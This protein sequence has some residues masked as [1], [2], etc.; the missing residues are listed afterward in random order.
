MPILALDIKRLLIVRWAKAVEHFQAVD[1]SPTGQQFLATIAQAIAATIKKVAFNLS[2]PCHDLDQAM[3][4]AGFPSGIEAPIA[5]IGKDAQEAID[6][7]EHTLHSMDRDAAKVLESAVIV[8]IGAVV[9]GMYEVDLLAFAGAIVECSQAVGEKSGTHQAIR[10][11]QT[12]QNVFL[13]D[14]LCL[15][16]GRRLEDVFQWIY[17]LWD[18]QVQEGT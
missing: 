2:L 14:L 9:A 3:Q 17:C 11:F 18:L 16:D 12:K 5:R 1:A 7:D 15:L 4:S 13:R 6:R 10:A 8:A